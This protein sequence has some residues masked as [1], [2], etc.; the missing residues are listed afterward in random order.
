MAG[1]EPAWFRP[2]PFCREVL[3][4]VFRELGVI[5]PETAESLNQHPEEFREAVRTVGRAV[6]TL[7]L[8]IRN[9]LRPLFI[10]GINLAADVVHG[11]IYRQIF[12]FM[13]QGYLDNDIFNTTL[14]C[15]AIV[16][17]LILFLSDFGL[18]IPHYWFP[19]PWCAIYEHRLRRE[20]ES[21]GGWER[22]LEEARL[23]Y[24]DTEFYRETSLSFLN[25]NPIPYAE[26]RGGNNWP[27]NP[28]EFL[29]E[30]F[31]VTPR[32]TTLAMRILRELYRHEGRLTPTPGA[33]AYAIRSML[34]LQDRDEDHW[35]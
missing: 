11:D 13:T 30:R 22:L 1:R 32:S 17:E 7:Q 5:P 33:G 35:C 20:L 12:Y 34:G 10:E 23:R 16:A 31:G 2:E 4:F 28:L 9:R 3:H 15:F 26:V 21:N 29:H 14:S 8:V 24:T 6:F 19:M 27:D 18:P 25:N